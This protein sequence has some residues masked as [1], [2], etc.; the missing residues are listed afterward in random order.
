MRVT[1]TFEHNEEEEGFNG[2]TTHSRDGVENLY[3]LAN[4]FLAAA[5]AAGF[6]YVEDVGFRKDNGDEMWGHGR[7]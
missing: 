6:T 5:A 4:S 1:I 2:L 3:D 7:W